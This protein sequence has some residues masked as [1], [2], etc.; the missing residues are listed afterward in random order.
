MEGDTLLLWEHALAAA[1]EKE[2]DGTPASATEVQPLITLYRMGMRL[3][4]QTTTTPPAVSKATVRA[5]RLVLV[6][7]VS[8]GRGT[9]A[10]RSTENP[11]AKEITCHA[12]STLPNVRLPLLG[13]D[14]MAFHCEWCG[15]VLARC[16]CPAP[17]LR[18]NV[19]SADA[20]DKAGAG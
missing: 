7:G 9:L 3:P 17:S 5:G 18:P 16:L 6:Y 10:I 4:P 1:V 13:S 15:N 19:A 8:T 20:A 2:Q 11:A 14:G 12:A